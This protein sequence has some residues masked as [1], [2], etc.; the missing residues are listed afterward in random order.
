M[1]GRR[2]DRHRAP[3]LAQRDQ[4]HLCPPR[5]AQQKFASNVVERMLKLDFGSEDGGEGGGEGEIDASL[6]PTT[7]AL[8]DAVVLELAAT[9]ALPRLLQDPYANYVVQ[10]AL[11]A[12]GP[13][14][15]AALAE[16]VKPHL[17]AL[18]GTPHGKRVAARVVAR[19]ALAA[20]AAGADAAPVVDAA[21]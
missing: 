16:A 6:L 10:S 20:A 2:D 8:C 13:V 17:P 3:R 1:C 7:Q 11:A 21:A 14:A 12:G 18:R 9:P 4:F 19:E 15:G 5:L